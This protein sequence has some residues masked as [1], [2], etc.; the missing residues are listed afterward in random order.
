MEAP[1]LL[2]SPEEDKRA[3]LKGRPKKLERNGNAADVRRI[4]H[5]ISC[6]DCIPLSVRGRARPAGKRNYPG[7]AVAKAVILQT[8]MNGR[9]RVLVEECE[10]MVLMLGAHA[11]GAD[12]DQLK[13]E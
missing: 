11:F 7:A 13:G 12:C 6:T 1:E 3:V 10:A 9:H 2:E 5:S 4:E 8:R